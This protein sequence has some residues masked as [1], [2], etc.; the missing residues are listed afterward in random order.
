MKYFLILGASS[1]K[2]LIIAHQY[3][4]SKDKKI[5][6]EFA[7]NIK[8]WILS[9]SPAFWT[10]RG[11]GKELSIE[12]KSKEHVKQLVLPNEDNIL[13]EGYLGKLK[14]LSF[15]EGIMLEIEGTNGILRMDLSEEE[16]KRLL[17]IK[18]RID[19]KLGKGV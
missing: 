15:Y 8:K 13:I 7:L 2:A 19:K 10:S 1:F 4:G 5:C 18:T 11:Y 16:W 9:V 14:N 17:S 3:M 12:L 6:P